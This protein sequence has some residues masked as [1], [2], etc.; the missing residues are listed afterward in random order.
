MSVFPDG[1]NGYASTKGRVR[2]DILAR[3]RKL[4]VAQRAAADDRIA[5]GLR[6]L[7]AVRRPGLVAG[8]VPFGTEPG[9]DWLP[10]LLAEAVG[11]GDR[12]L[13]PVLLAD[14][15]LDWAPLHDPDGERWGTAAVAGVDLVVVPALA[16]D[17][18]GV[19]LGRGGGSYDRALARVPAGVPVVALLYDGELLPRLPAQPHDRPVTAVVTPGGLHWLADQGGGR[20]A[21]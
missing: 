10:P 1:A 2:T 20:P 4:T 9:G 7:L 15:D 14:R 21:G 19:R 13:L 6:E 16:V 5:A 3:R 18:R 17:Q 8:Y 11:G 12:V